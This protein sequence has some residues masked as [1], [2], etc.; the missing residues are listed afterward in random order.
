MSIYGHVGA[1]RG[2]K[3]SS[4]IVKLELQVNMGSLHGC[5]ELNWC[6]LKEQYTLLLAEP[7]LQPFKLILRDN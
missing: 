6:P 3:S 7:S 4:D 1:P 2:L 5:W